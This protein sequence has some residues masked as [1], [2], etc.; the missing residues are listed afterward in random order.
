MPNV[1]NCQ[2]VSCSWA[3]GI[4][5]CNDSNEKWASPSCST[6][7]DN[8]QQ[9]LDNCKS[10]ALVNGEQLTQGSPSSGMMMDGMSTWA[11]PT[12]K[13]RQGKTNPD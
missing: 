6:V 3:S 11:M 8:A 12:A 7:A 13:E 2:R 10:V 5:V 4:Y 9:I 1:V